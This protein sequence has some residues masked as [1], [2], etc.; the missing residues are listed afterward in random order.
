MLRKTLQ[1]LRETFASWR[2][3]KA[4]RLGAALAY[5]TIFSIPPLLLLLIGMAGTLFGRDAVQERMVRSIEQMT[6]PQGAE[7]VRGMLAVD[8]GQRRGTIATVIGA[9]TL[10]LGASGVFGQ[11]KDALNTLWGVR[12]KPGKGLWSFFRSYFL[13]LVALF[14]TGFLLIVS[15]AANAMLGAFGEYLERALPGGAGLWQTINVFITWFVIAFLFGMMFKYI[16]DAKVAWRD[17]LVGGLVTS[18]LFTAG[19][20]AIGF[21]LGRSNVGSAFGAAGSLVILLVW[22]YYSALILFFGAEF[23]KTFAKHVG[24][25]LRPLGNAEPITE[26]ARREEG[27][28]RDDDRE[29]ER[30]AGT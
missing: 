28:P 10:L 1:L 23:T 5:Y 3:D 15:L 8:P 11:L 4:T 16:P 14:G 6:G 26:E 7:A 9:I 29:R 22:V 19:Q 17:A 13:S 12:P 21:Y 18:G 24:A 25:G 30:R 20:A 27:I 2:E